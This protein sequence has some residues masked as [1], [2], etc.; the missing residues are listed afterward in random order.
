MFKHLWM[1]SK[2][3]K[4]LL[5]FV[6]RCLL[7]VAYPLQVAEPTDPTGAVTLCKAHE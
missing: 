2:L 7:Q 4:L 5:D 3:G 1:P 6:C